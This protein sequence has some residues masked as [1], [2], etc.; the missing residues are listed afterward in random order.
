MWLDQELLLLP[1]G[2]RSFLVCIHSSA[3]CH[4]CMTMFTI[5]DTAAGVPKGRSKSS[6]DRACDQCKA[7]KVRCD[8]SNPC[9]RCVGKNFGCTYKDERKRR[10]PVGRRISKIQRPQHSASGDVLRWRTSPASDILSTTSTPKQQ[11]TSDPHIP[12]SHNSAPDGPL[13]SAEAS[14]LSMNLGS[15]THQVSVSSLPGTGEEVSHQTEPRRGDLGRHKDDFLLPSL[16][17]D[18]H[19]NNLDLFASM[20]PQ[21]LPPI[22]GA[23]KFWPWGI[24][25]EAMLPWMDVYFERLHPTVPVLNRTTLYQEM[26]LRR[27][28]HDPQFGAM[29]L[30]LCAFA[31]TQPVQIHEIQSAPSRSAQANILLEESVKMRTT[32]DFGEN[33]SL[34]MVLTSFFIFACLF[35]SGLH[36]AAH[37]RLREAVDL[38]TALSMH[39]PQ[40][41]DSLDIETREQWLRT[42]LVLSVT[43]R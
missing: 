31:M 36:K 28:H 4:D 11:D 18:S 35:G 14:K 40:A 20:G 21:D 17:M 33:P 32:V 5:L 6:A 7:R 38:A 26:I 12:D 1:M 42:Y 8:M 43:E 15:P 41:Y 2:Q 23:V 39:L 29:L 34:H 30:A 3:A 25:Q 9:V 13:P 16:P 22:V 19:P 37:H 24:S 10:G 27:H